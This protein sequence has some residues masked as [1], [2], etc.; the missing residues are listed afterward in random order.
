MTPQDLAGKRVTVMGLGRHGGG[1]AAAR[2]LAEEGA[3]VTVTDLASESDL[4]ASLRELA[5][6]PIARFHLGGHLEQDFCG[7]DVVV[8]NPAVKPDNAL[9]QMARKAGV[10]ISSEMELFLD[11]CRGHLIGVTG[12]N[13]KSTTAAMTAAILSAGGRRTWLGGNIGKS[14]LADLPQIGPDDWSVVELSSFQLHWLSSTARMPEV[15]VITNCMPNH[16]DWHPAWEHYVAAKQR[17]LTGQRPCDAAV[18]NLEDAEVASWRGLVRGRCMQIPADEE[19]PTLLVPGRHNRRNAASA[20]AAAKAAGYDWAD[21]LRGLAEFRGLPHRLEFVGEVQ[22]RR[23]YNDSKATT[24]EAARAALATF[25]NVWLLAGGVD[26]GSDYSGFARAVA[27]QTRGAAFFGAAR[28][29]LHAM[30]TRASPLGEMNCVETMREAFQ[31][32]WRQSQAGDAILLS[33]ACASLDQFVDYQHRGESFKQL[34][35]ALT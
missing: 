5:N 28:D 15:A 14:L 8:V 20:A 12:S 11:A 3:K 22:G 35:R 25:G 29:A 26:K 17:L 6:A 31:W 33:P 34:V 23:F 9:V 13:G 19:I 32:C 30:V 7:T 24:P 10:Q 16:L 21:I 18:L 1:V 27:N 4:A 2:Y